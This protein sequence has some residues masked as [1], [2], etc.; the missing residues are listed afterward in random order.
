[1]F[2]YVEKYGSTALHHASSKG[3]SMI[4]QTILAS[5]RFSSINDKT[6]VSVPMAFEYST[7]H[8]IYSMGILHCIMLHIMD[9]PL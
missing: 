3:H 5:E 4:V 2:L 9:I 1:M 6:N 7:V 8:N